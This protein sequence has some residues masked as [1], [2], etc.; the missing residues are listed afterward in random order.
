[1]AKPDKT[2]DFSPYPAPDFSAASS[3]GG[4]VA[5]DDLKGRWTVLFLYPRDD[6]PG[7]TQESCEFS[8]ALADFKALGA[9]LYGLSKDGLKAHEKFIAK[10]GLAMP[11]LSDPDNAAIAAFG[12][13]IEKS[14]YGR[15]YMGT[16]R[17]TF[18]IDPEGR[19]RHVW[20][21]VK[22]KGHVADVLAALRTLVSVR[23]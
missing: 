15:K 20:R 3:A 7:C 6:T 11:L 22:V 2:G 13:W 8:A 4:T 18:I 12:S 16:D 23:A 5:R 21:G 10:Y 17:S 14:L 1:M 9:Q 19:V